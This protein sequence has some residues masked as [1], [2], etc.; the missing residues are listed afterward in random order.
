[1]LAYSLRFDVVE[2][3]F[4]NVFKYYITNHRNQEYRKK[5][6]CTDLHFLYNN[7]SKR[8]SS[9]SYFN[10]HIILSHVLYVQEEEDAP[11]GDQLGL[12]A[13][14][15]TLREALDTIMEQKTK[16]ESSFQ[17]DKKKYLVYD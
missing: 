3:F 13:Q 6:C 2:R 5:I 7:N 9:C 10:P 14:V 8:V 17:A 1:M 4:L 16:M 12:Q 15:K 11:S